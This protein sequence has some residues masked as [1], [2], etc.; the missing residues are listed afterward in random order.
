MPIVR[1]NWKE[2]SRIDWGNDMEES[3]FPGRE[4]IQ[5]GAILRIADAME[6]M[7][8][9]HTSLVEE[10]ER[11]RKWYQ[12]EREMRAQAYRTVTRLRGVITRLKKNKGK[13]HVKY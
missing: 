13:Y 12:E 9:N 5:L 11:Y 3:L 2:Q 6:A 7:A 10:K 1:K 4:A 8:K